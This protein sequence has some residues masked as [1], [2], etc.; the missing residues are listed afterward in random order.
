MRG[1]EVGRE[2]E[3]VADRRTLPGSRYRSRSSCRWESGRSSSR[4][5]RL[6]TRSGHG[7]PRSD[8]VTDDDRVRV[9]RRRDLRRDRPPAAEAARR[10]QHH[11]PELLARAARAS[12]RDIDAGAKA[13]VIVISSTGKHFSAGMDLSVFTGESGLGGDGRRRARSAGVGAYLWMMVQHLQDSFT[14]LEQARMPVLTAIQGGC[15]GGAVDMVS[16]RRPAL[17]HRRRLLL[18]PGDQ[19]RHDRRRRHAAA[20]PEDHPRG[21]RPRAAPTPATACRPQRALEVGLVNQVFDDHESLVDGRAGRSPGASP[22]T[23]PSRS[24]APRR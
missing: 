16:R 23:R 4:R 18:H 19:H 6:P 13:R 17:L 5:R 3:V 15:I 22:P 1:L 9:L 2:L 20:A 12:C 8:T 21:H 10:A 14:A 11:D 7:S 24:G